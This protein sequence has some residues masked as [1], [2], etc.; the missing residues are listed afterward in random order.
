MNIFLGIGS[1][2][3]QMTQ[4]NVNDLA[5]IKAQHLKVLPVKGGYS[6][7]IKFFYVEFILK[8]TYLILFYYT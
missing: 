2:N 8:N 4:L 3:T 7:K 5:Q 6:Q 1:Y